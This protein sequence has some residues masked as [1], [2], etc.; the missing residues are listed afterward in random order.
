M[1]VV[2]PTKFTMLLPCP[3]CSRPFPNKGPNGVTRRYCSRSC[4][5][6]GHHR[7]PFAPR[8]WAKVE[9]TDGCWLWRG[10]ISQ[11]GYGATTVD[12]QKQRAHRVA[13]ALTHGPIPEGLLV[14]HTCDNRLC[15]N[16]DHLF[17]GT[18]A[19]NSRDMV[20]KG[21]QARAGDNGSYTH[22][23]SRLRG[24]QNTA[25][26]LTADAVREIRRLHAQRALN[27]KELAARFGV[28]GTRVSQIVRRLS[29][30]HLE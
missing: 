5:A 13:Y 15:V 23:E 6:I 21:R 10:G 28:S 30:Q 3:I 25:H 16:P 24:E 22:P 20:A 8:F 1:E 11:D 2:M 12:A 17:L 26:K 19:E 14:C 9:K 18:P 29:W 7:Q 27:G 4:A